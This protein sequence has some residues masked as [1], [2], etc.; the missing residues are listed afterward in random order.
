MKKY[1]C[2][3]GFPVSAYDKHGNEL[4]ENDSYI[5]AGTVWELREDDPLFMPAHGLVK[6][7]RDIELPFG[8]VFRD[9]IE[10][11]EDWLRRYF[12]PVLKREVTEA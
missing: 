10:I 12:K 11:D 4:E 5:E 1:R 2:I 7:S 6:L 3:K 9:E 8:D